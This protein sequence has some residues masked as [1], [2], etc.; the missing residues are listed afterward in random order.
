MLISL[1]L[2]DKAL[3]ILL[4]KYHRKYMIKEVLNKRIFH[5]FWVKRCQYLTEVLVVNKLNVLMKACI[6]H[7]FHN[8]YVI[9]NN[10][11]IMWYRLP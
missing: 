8:V 11:Y 7:R 1:I 2:S 5:V 9:P 10:G 4:Q 6:Q 3:D